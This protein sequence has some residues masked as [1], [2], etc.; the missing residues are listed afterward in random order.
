MKDKFTIELT[1]HNCFT[2]PP[3][4][5]WNNNLYISDGQY[6]SHATYDSHYGWFDRSAGDYIPFESLHEYY[7]ADIEQTVQTSQAFQM[8]IKEN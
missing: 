1:W 5:S 4:E 2:Y 8:N 3:K 7:W 6:V